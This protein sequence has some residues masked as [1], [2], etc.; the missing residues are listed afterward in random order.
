MTGVPAWIANVKLASDQGRDIGT[1]M[2]LLIFVK[3][4]IDCLIMTQW[5]LERITKL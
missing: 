2:S 3:G 5:N 4:K 1:L